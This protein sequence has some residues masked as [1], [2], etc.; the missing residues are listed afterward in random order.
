MPAALPG[1]IEGTVKWGPEP[2]PPKR[3]PDTQGTD[4]MK[5]DRRWLKSAL[6]ASQDTTISMPWARGNRRKPQAMKI[7]SGATKSRTAAAR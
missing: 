3:P 2:V 5:K 7:V 4:P 6:A 1:Q